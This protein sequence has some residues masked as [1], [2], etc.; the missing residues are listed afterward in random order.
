MSHIHNR[1]CYNIPIDMWPSL[2]FVFF[3]S[4]NFNLNLHICPKILYDR[5]FGNIAFSLNIINTSKY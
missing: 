1:S 5:V 3:F 2:G 4:S